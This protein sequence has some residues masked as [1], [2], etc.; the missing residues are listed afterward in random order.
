MAYSVSRKVYESVP[1]IVSGRSLYP[2]GGFA[3]SGDVLWLLGL[4][5]SYWFDI[6]WV[7]AT[8]TIKHPPVH[9]PTPHS[10]E[11]S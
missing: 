10:K 5:R 4:G 7:E 3:V 8:N 6:E 11:L 2:G 9:R 1:F